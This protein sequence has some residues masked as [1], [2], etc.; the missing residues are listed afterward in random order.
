MIDL[1]TVE[2]FPVFR[3]AQRGLIDQDTCH[4]LLEAQLVMG[5][6]VQPGAPHRL[7]LEQALS[8]GLIDP[9]TK[10]SLSELEGAL[11]LLDN[12][13]P[14]GQQ[15]MLPV[16]A[17]MEAGLITEAAGLRIL[18]LQLNTGGL[19]DSEG[20]V[21]SV[22][23]AEDRR[24]LSPRTVSRLQSRLQHK[25]LI[26][27]NTAEKLS[28]SELQ[29]R[30]VA[31]GD[32]GLLLLPVKQQPGGT[33]CLRSGRKVGIFRAV[34]EGLID[35]KVTVRLLEAQ[36]FAGGVADP[37]SGHRLSIDEAVRHGLMDQDLACTMLARQLQNG[38]I[39]DPL[40]GERLDLEESIHKD[41]LSPRLAVLVLESL[42]T[43]MGI[44]WPES[45]ELLPIAEAL[46]QGVISAELSR[47]ILRQRHAIGALYEPETLQVLPLDQEAGQVLQPDV[48]RVLRDIHI[49]DVI[50]SMSHSGTPAL[51][52]SSWGSSS[53]SPPPSSPPPSAPPEGLVWDS[54]PTHDMDPKDQAK[55][56]LLFYVMTHSYVDAHSGRRLV[57][58][59]PELVELV[60]AAEAVGEMEV[61][62]Q[63]GVSTVKQEKL[64]MVQRESSHKDGRGQQTGAKEERSRDFEKSFTGRQKTPDRESEKAKIETGSRTESKLRDV[65]KT[66]QATLQSE[67]DESTQSD[68]RKHVKHFHPESEEMDLEEPVPETDSKPE[69]ED[70]E[71]AR[72][73]QELQQGGLMTEDGEKLLPD[74]AVA[75]GLLPGHTA[76]KLMAEAKLFGGFL[77][78]TSVESLS[79]EDVMQEGLLDEDLMWSVLKSDK[80]LAGVVDVER[81]QIC[82]VREAAQAGLIDPDTA[83]RLLEAQVASGG[84]VDL[85]RDKKVS[86]T[87]AANLGLIEEDQREELVALEKAF[88]GKDTD[89]ATALTK[90]SLQLQMEGVVDPESTTP[91]PLEQAIQRGLIQPEEAYQVL[92][93]QVLEGGV[94]HHASGMRLSVSDAVDRGLVDRSIAPGLEELEWIS[95]GKLSPSSHPDVVAFQASTGAVL[96]PES[97]CKLTLTEAVSKGLLDERSASEAMASA[98][99][100]QG[101]IDPQT[102]RVVPYSELVNQ[103]KI[104][105]ETGKRFLEVKPF[106][107]VQDERTGENLTLLEAVAS[108]QV[109]PIPALRLLQS[110]SDTGGIIDIST[111]ERLPLPEA[112]SRG[113]I[114]DSMVK[115]IATNQFLKGGLIDP[116]TGEQVSS[117]DD[118]IAKGLI[119]SDVASEIQEKLASMEF[120]GGEGSATPVASS[121]GTYSPAAGASQSSPDS[122]ELPTRSSASKRD[123]AVKQGV[124][125]TSTPEESDQSVLDDSSSDKEEPAVTEPDQAIDLL[126]RFASDVEKRIQQ[127]IEEISPQTSISRSEQDRPGQRGTDSTQAHDGDTERK[128]QEE[129]TV[130][131]SKREDVERDSGDG[132]LTGSAAAEMKDGRGGGTEPSKLS[133]DG[134]RKRDVSGKREEVGDEKDGAREEKEKPGAGVTQSDQPTSP[135]EVM[136]SK[137]KKKRKSKKNGKGKEAESESAEVKHP[138]GVKA[139]VEEQSEAVVASEDK[140]KLL[141]HKDETVSDVRPEAAPALQSTERKPG[142][143]DTVERE[144]TGQADVMEQLKLEEAGGAAEE[145][146]IEEE[147]Q[148]QKSALPDEKKAALV[149]KAKESI[150]KKVFEKGVSEKQTAKELQA[151]R[152]E[153]G[154]KESHGKDSK[155]QGA[156]EGLSTTDD[157]AKRVNGSQSESEVEAR[158]AAAVEETPLRTKETEIK[159]LEELEPEELQRDAAAQPKDNQQNKRS[160][161]KK[162]SKGLKAAEAPEKP[163]PEVSASEDDTSVKAKPGLDPS[164][165][166]QEQQVEPSVH[167]AVTASAAV[168]EE[169]EE[170]SEG[171]THQPEDPQSSIR[172]SVESTERESISESSRPAEPRAAAQAKA[173]KGKKKKKHKGEDEAAKVPETRP[174]KDQQQH[175]ESPESA[176]ESPGAPESDTTSESLEEGDED[177][178]DKAAKAGKVAGRPSA[179]GLSARTESHQVFSASL[180]LQAALRRQEYLELD[181]RM[182]AL[183]SMVRHLEVRLKQQQQQSVG[184]SLVALDD[185]ITQTEVRR[186]GR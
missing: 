55:H 168:E 41:L 126:S 106:K 16:A 13:S 64:Q 59:D 14:G 140:Q 170:A 18:E 162:K 11:A 93:R 104:D 156:S 159:L 46:Q 42:W 2:T 85:R 51:N 116:S 151:L 56:K 143:K 36:L 79:L 37:R 89:S 19:R 98:G 171:L 24:L 10:R 107:G 71:L 101:V 102:A 173:A 180:L 122:C 53:S 113:L 132:A 43:F 181:Q 184:R 77:D 142:V 88:R 175:L 83:A 90:A 1:G 47:S 99:V 167:D 9:H 115:E 95:Q 87:L 182:V 75:Q 30:C 94:I 66:D 7:S 129:K 44:L 84:I 12:Q 127:S 160:K 103:G 80:T 118:A 20:A 123:S 176:P 27:P 179:P 96:D 137:S 72:L 119:S 152:S 124:R 153:L 5:G 73:V 49:P 141:S 163:Q 63:N 23:Q 78:A 15:Q 65:N 172:D 133:D 148:P 58:L 105:I 21:L 4:V 54:A 121:N 120:E 8:R 76:V 31:D 57:L 183:V 157:G 154:R 174:E 48:V 149:L 33:V 155:T 28:L 50:S 146:S 111:G 35:R 114:G 169:E 110:Q 62:P 135:S 32:S 164:A 68:V 147:L 178:R 74:E 134:V 52:R 86:V 145:Q 67:T 128:S 130:V 39:I 38:G 186:R 81:S 82:G 17:A 34:Q 3:A 161:K 139:D 112:C 185:I 69:G 25:Q 150:L 136:Q 165:L 166:V 22:E 91:V 70:G 61:E 144:D 125:Q 177:A 100:T 60:K 97:G 108:Q 109:D 92:A 117:L 6:L 26:D 131:T 138:S 40:S 45:G 158:E 29:Q